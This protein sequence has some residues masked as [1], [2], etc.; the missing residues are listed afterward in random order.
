MTD[1][2]DDNICPDCGCSPTHYDPDF[3]CTCEQN[4]PVPSWAEDTVPLAV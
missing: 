3:R 2:D 4:E 1:L